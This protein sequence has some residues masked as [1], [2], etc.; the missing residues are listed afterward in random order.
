MRHLFVIGT[1]LFLLAC[2]LKAESFFLVDQG[3]SGTAKSGMHTASVQDA[4][5][6]FYNPAQLAQ[7]RTYDFSATGTLMFPSLTY[8]TRSGN[9]YDGSKRILPI[10]SMF[11]SLPVSDRVTL[12]LGATTPATGDNAWGGNFPGR[13]SSSRYKLMMN[14]V[15]F[16][17]GF[18]L[19]DRVRFGISA[20]YSTSSMIYENHVVAPYYDVIGGTDEWLGLYEAKG[21]L[22]GSATAGGFTAGLSVDVTRRWTVSLTYKSKQEFDFEAEPVAFTQVTGTNIPN[23]VRSFETEFAA[24]ESMTTAF[25]SPAVYTLGVAYRPNNRWV[26][27]LDFANYQFSDVR[28]YYF[29][30]SINT[31]SIIDRGMTVPWD[32]M[33]VYGFSLEYQASKEIRLMGG[34]RFASDVIP[35]TDTNP[36]DPS[37]NKFYISLG[38]SYLD[39]GDGWSFALLFKT[40]KDETIA[41]QE[42]LINPNYPGYLEPLDNTGL[43][44]RHSIGFSVTYHIRF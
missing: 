39:E 37:T 2:P 27:E 18:K 29:D 38:M 6:L 21:T 10:G 16:G 41:D 7:V 5:A 31:D 42:F 20:D 17:A 40:Y 14:T 30:Y 36:A 23:A 11:L 22:D 19:A 8:S 3:A 24:A 32:D 34:M 43:Y 1:A 15:S 44:D 35:L 28:P 26:M 9:S 33:T 12:G 4:S 13:F 25:D